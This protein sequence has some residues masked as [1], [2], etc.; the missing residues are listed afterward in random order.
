MKQNANTVFMEED[1][2]RKEAWAYLTEDIKDD[3]DRRVLEVLCENQKNF[4]EQKYKMDLESLQEINTTGNIDP[5][6]TYAF[7]LMRRIYPNLIGKELVSVQPIPQPTGKIFYID[8]SYGADLAPTKKGDQFAWNN[9]DPTS[10]KMAKFNPYYALGRAKGETLGTGDGTNKVFK[11]ALAPVFANSLVLYVNSVAVTTFTI[12]TNDPVNGVTI[13]CTTAPASGLTVTAD[14]IQNTEGQK[15]VPEID[16]AITDAS[17][18]P[19]HV[20]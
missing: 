12:Q 8:F 13:Q 15:Y 14:Y 4:Y 6:T 18:S 5:F 1:A 9:S 7:P 20:R 3:Y 11:T 19:K 17:I 16:F 10:D 2:A